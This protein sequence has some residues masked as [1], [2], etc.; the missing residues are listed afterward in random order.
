MSKILVTGGM[1]F[2]GSAFIR[3]AESV[4]HQC[5]CVDNHAFGSHPRNLD[6]TICLKNEMSVNADICDMNAIQHI[7]KS[8]KPAWIAHFAAHSHVDRSIS[9]PLSFI[10]RGQT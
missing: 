1:G 4:G 5:F 7:L 2:I 10:R 9:E 8:F 3:L 6:G